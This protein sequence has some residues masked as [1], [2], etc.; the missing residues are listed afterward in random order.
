M[1]LL[2]KLSFSIEYKDNLKVS[3]FSVLSA[4]FPCLR[5][6][7]GNHVFRRTGHYIDTPTARR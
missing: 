2:T 6:N 3:M 7:C 5:N 1:K 4:I